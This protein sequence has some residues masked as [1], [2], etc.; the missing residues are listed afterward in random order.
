MD[1]LSTSILNSVKRFGGRSPATTQIDGRI[2]TEEVNDPQLHVNEHVCRS[3][4]GTRA[5]N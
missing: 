1:M 5:T 4:S 3:G 2:E